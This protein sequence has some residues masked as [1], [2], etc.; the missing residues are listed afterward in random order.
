[1]NMWILE[2]EFVFHI[3]IQNLIQNSFFSGSVPGQSHELTSVFFLTKVKS[4][5]WPDFNVMA[6][7]QVWSYLSDHVLTVSIRVLE[8]CLINRFPKVSPSYKK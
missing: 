1:M 2:L 5:N 7:E 6:L 3:Q 8:Q 4:L